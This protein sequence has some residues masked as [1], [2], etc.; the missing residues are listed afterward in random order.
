MDETALIRA[1][2]RGDV[3]SYNTLVLTH[4]TQ[5]FNVAY[6]I[7]GD[8]DSAADAT[9]EAFISAFKAIRTFRGGS[10]KAWLLRIV[11]NACYDEIRR[12][13]RRPNA[14]LDALYVEDESAD[15]DGSLVTRA[16]NPEQYAQRM[17]LQAAIVSC[18]QGLSE[19]QR[20]VTVLSDIEGMSYEE[21]SDV[22]GAALGTVKS[23]LSRARSS[24]RDCLQGYGEL[25]PASYRL[26]T[27][28]S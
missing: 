8:P 7:M 26:N 6:R 21:I 24:L 25:L 12:R 2:Q 19:D 22:I 27:E 23:R 10:F 1:A 20:T 4:Q 11:T 5:A 28:N 16:E 3:N 18:L 14:S 17:D 15:S 13:K 9:Q